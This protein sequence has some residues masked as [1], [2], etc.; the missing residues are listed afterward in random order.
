MTVAELI[1][2]LKVLPSTALVWFYDGDSGG[3]SRV[4]GVDMK[5]PLTSSWELKKF[6]GHTNHVLISD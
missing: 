3:W 1:E 2:A 5:G 6:D 4:G